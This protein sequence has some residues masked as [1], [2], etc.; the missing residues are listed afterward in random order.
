M[1]TWN[2]DTTTPATLDAD[3]FTPEQRQRL[4]ALRERAQT[5]PDVGEFGLDLRRL[6]F[7]RWLVE[8]GRL[9]EDLPAGEESGVLSA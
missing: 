4:L 6:Q 3:A 9:S 7:A 1:M 2:P 5:Q 8:T